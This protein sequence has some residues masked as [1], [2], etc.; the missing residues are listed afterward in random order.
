MRDDDPT[1]LPEQMSWI[2]S[3]RFSRRAVLASG[4]AVSGYALAAQPVAPTAI[5]T[6]TD[7][8][9]EADLTFTASNGFAMKAYRARPMGRKNAPVIIVVQEIF[10]LHE[11]IRDMVRRYAKAGFYA[12]APDLYGRE[13][14]A[15][16]SPDI[17]SVVRDFVMK[18]SDRQV[19]ADLDALA[20]FVPADGGDAN[21]L[22][23]TG[24]CWGG[25]VVWMY[26]AHNPHVK[27][28]VAHY[29]RLLP[30]DGQPEAPIKEVARIDAPILG[31]YG[32]KDRGIPVADVEQM[33][34]ALKAANKPSRI[35]VFPDA[36]HGFMADYR[37]SYHA[38][39][40]RRA[41][42]M[43]MAWFKRYLRMKP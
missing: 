6:R 18:T 43:E 37:P 40:A 21:R 26:A 41:W 22:G 11:W 1:R 7:G 13:G 20:A 29:G 30:G 9:D 5:R 19:M 39:S 31:L 35:E 15:T 28:G 23:I 33:R 14:D 8:L 25:R 12:I 2:D 17:P 32:G 3:T 34:T 42:S 10:G 36:E 24:F 4:I 38:A 16:K 27:A